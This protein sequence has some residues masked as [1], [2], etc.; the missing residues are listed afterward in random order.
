MNALPLIPVVVTFL[1]WVAIFTTG[2]YSLPPIKRLLVIAAVAGALMLPV[3]DTT[4]FLYLR[5]VFGDFSA[6]HVLWALAALVNRILSRQVIVIPRRQKIAVA[7]LLVLL[8]AGF[9]PSALGAIH[10]DIYR[11]GFEPRLMLIVLAAVALLAW[12][13]R[14]YFLLASIVTAVLAFRFRIL[15]S[16]NLWDYL[17][18]PILVLYC[19]AWLVIS[20]LQFVFRRAMQRPEPASNYG[21]AIAAQP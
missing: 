21:A 10:F 8:A 14:Q 16:T 11:F 3:F 7:L 2:A 18:D 5:G 12:Q 6:T 13:W 4:P 15:E 19:G 1:V 9:Y 20:L 17:F